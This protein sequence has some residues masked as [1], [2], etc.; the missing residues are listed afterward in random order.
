MTAAPAEVAEILGIPSGRRALRRTKPAATT[1]SVTSITTTWFP[2]AIA[3]EAPRLADS[4]PLPA[5][6]LAYIAEA[7]GAAPPA[8]TRTTAAVAAS[9]DTAA[10][11]GVPARL[12]G[13][14]HPRSVRE[15][16]RTAHRTRP[17]PQPD[18][19]TGAFGRTPFL[20]SDREDV[21]RA[22]GRGPFLVSVR[23]LMPRTRPLGWRRQPFQE[24]VVWQCTLVGQYL[25]ELAS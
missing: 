14:A 6:T 1:A 16:R 19:T 8:C 10:T 24:A 22:P 25:V 2:P 18:P 23:F 13:A 15:R 21:Q 20:A 3:A 17:R 5:G 4:Q 11:L 7:T 9:D 12:A